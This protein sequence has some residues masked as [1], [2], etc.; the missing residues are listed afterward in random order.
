VR[1]DPL[2]PATKA[3]RDGAAWVLDGSKLCVPAAQLAHRILIPAATADGGVGIFLLDPRA[4]GV[5]L[6][7]LSTT[8]G[9][10]EAR[11]DLAGVRIDG[12]DLLG[13][14]G[15]GRAML[16]WLVERAQ[17]ALAAIALG[18]C[19]EALRLTAEYVKTRKQFDQPIAMFQAVAHRAANA[20]IDTEGVRLT[21]WQAASRLA[22]G[23]VAGPE[24]ALA[25]FWAAEAATASCMPP[26]TSTAASASIATTRCIATSSTRATSS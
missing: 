26:S 16:R 15:T 22:A 1:G 8:S 21:V 20:Y 24:V 25:K 4:K 10:P 13:E 7:A 5:T 3:R 23:E 9:Q 2:A 18:C 11:L 6:T 17:A 14:P 19:E 12:A